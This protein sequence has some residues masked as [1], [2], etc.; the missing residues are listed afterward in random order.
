M[1]KVDKGAFKSG[2]ESGQGS[3]VENL[4]GSFQCN[5]RSG[6]VIKCSNNGSPCTYTSH[7]DG[8]TGIMVS[9]TKV[10]IGE[11][12]TLSPGSSTGIVVNLTMAGIQELL[13]HRSRK[14]TD[15]TT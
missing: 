12:L 6:G 13:T 9:Q 7:H 11:S 3:Y 14:A 8:D 5:L 15:E 1:A 2:C 4:D 10:G